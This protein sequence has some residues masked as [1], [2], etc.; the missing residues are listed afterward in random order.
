VLESNLR[1]KGIAAIYV[2]ASDKPLKP[3][4]QTEKLTKTCQIPTPITPDK[5]IFL[6]L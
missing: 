4:N 6:K 2:E 3:V 1:S 5:I